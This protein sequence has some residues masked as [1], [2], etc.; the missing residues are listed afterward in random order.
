MKRELTW[1]EGGLGVTRPWV[2]ESDIATPKRVVLAD[3]TL[4]AVEFYQRASE[5]TAY[6]YKGDFQNAKQL[7]Q[8]VQRRIDKT[9]EKKKARNDSAEPAPMAD[10]FHKHRQAQA[11]K[12]R[13]LSRLLIYVEPD[14]TIKLRRAPDVR[15]AITEAL[16]DVTGGFVVSLRELMGYIGAHEWRKKGVAIAALN[17]GRIHPYYG[18]FSPVRGEYLELVAKAPIKNVSTAFDIGTGTGVLAAILAARGVPKIIATDIDPRAIACASENIKQLRY[19]DQVEIL[20]TDL[21]PPGT[22]DL[23][24]CN[25]PW[26]PARPTSRIERAVYDENSHMLKSFLMGVT[27]HL[28]PAGEAW[29][30]M[31]N[32]AELLALRAQDDLQKWI[33]A[34][35]LEV[36]TF[37]EAKPRHAKS[38]DDEDLL[39]L[40]RSREVTRLWRLRART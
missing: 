29:L 18:I 1:Q 17:G 27:A 26:V 33:A 39:Y 24:L 38:I 8:A 25:P 19:T 32:L 7:L 11:H 28:N 34:A 14:L 23:I 2:T 10:L 21:F 5:G 20:Q 35:G 36:I 3:D 16:S 13:L 31:S 4:K 15:A 22:A 37:F 9:F 40:A 6:I 30:I 12:A